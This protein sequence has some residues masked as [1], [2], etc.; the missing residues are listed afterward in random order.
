MAA[1][2]KR[3]WKPY[4]VAGAQDILQH[5]CRHS[6]YMLN[7]SNIIAMRLL[8]NGWKAHRSLIPHMPVI[9]Q[10]SC[11]MLPGF[12]K[13]GMA[14]L[15][16]EAPMH[17]RLEPQH[18][19]PIRGSPDSCF[20]GHACACIQCIRAGEAHCR[21]QQPGAGQAQAARAWARH[22]RPGRWASPPTGCR[23][24]RR[25]P[26]AAPRRPALC[27]PAASPPAA[28]APAR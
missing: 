22:S 7:I 21:A 15:Q 13:K 9:L 27:A 12:S 5:L 24:S 2:W 25:W 11:N 16:H 3:S 10:K 6:I 28:A 20:R 1:S 14:G 26:P 4:V 23:S 17:A 8:C 18:H 19:L